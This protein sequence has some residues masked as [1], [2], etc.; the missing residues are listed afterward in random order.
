MELQK[1][2]YFYTVA[3]FGHVTRAAESLHVA[4]PALTQAIRSLERE[5]GVPLLEKRGRNIALTEC[6]VLLQARLEKLLPELDAI[7]NELQQLA[8]RVNK[9][10][11]LNLLAASSLIIEIIV[12]YRRTHPEVVFDFEQNGARLDCDIVISTNGVSVKNAPIPAARHVKEERIFL[13][14][15]RGSVYAAKGSVALSEVSEEEFV[16]LSSSRLFGALCNA[17]CSAA[18]FVPRILFESDSPAAVQNMIGAGTGVAFWPEYSWGNVQNPDVVLLP[19]SSP[20]CRRDL[21]IERFEHPSRSEF[22]EDFYRYL[23]ENIEKSRE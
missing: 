8:H 11:R 2:R 20:D 16:M 5:L 10:V 15:P 13:A 19:I 3:K 23:V 1:L 9:T 17:F 18:G 6:G 21:I 12:T 22:A 14:V 4:Q 7:P